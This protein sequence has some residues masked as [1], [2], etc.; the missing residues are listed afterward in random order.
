MTRG[1]VVD[2]SSE[3]VCDDDVEVMDSDVSAES[4]CVCRRGPRK[5]QSGHDLKTPKEYVEQS[6]G[7]MKVW[8]SQELKQNMWGTHEVR[9]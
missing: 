9:V 4:F 3:T 1:S 5:T 6:G 2:G 8:D 7:R